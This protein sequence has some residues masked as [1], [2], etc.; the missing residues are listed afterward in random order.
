MFQKES[1]YIRKKAFLQKVEKQSE[2]KLY[3]EIVSN[4]SYQHVCSRSMDFPCDKQEIDRN[5]G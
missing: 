2:V 4:R 3:D 1:S 5:S